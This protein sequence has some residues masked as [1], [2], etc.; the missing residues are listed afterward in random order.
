MNTGQMSLRTLYL[1]AGIEQKYEILILS[2]AV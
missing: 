2:D 1:L